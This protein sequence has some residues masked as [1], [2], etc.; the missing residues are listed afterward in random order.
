MS[1]LPPSGITD[2]KLEKM[3]ELFCLNN[4]AGDQVLT[5]QCVDL[6]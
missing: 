6:I 5:D 4:R 1:L 2:I 3:L